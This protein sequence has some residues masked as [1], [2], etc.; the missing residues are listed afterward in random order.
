MQAFKLQITSVSVTK[1]T[2]SSDSPPSGKEYL[3]Y[4]DVKAEKESSKTLSLGLWSFGKDREAQFSGLSYVAT[5]PIRV[6][7]FAKGLFAMD[8]GVHTLYQHL[9]GDKLTTTST[10]NNNDDNNNS[11]SSGTISSVVFG[12]LVFGTR[13]RG[14]AVVRVHYR[15]APV[16]HQFQI[17]LAESR[18]LSQSSWWPGGEHVVAEAGKSVFDLGWFRPLDSS[19]QNDFKI[20]IVAQMEAKFWVQSKLWPRSNAIGS[21]LFIP[22]DEIEEGDESTLLVKS[23]SPDAVISSEEGP[24]QLSIVTVVLARRFVFIFHV[25]TEPVSTIAVP[26]LEAPSLQSTDVMAV[27]EGSV[28]LTD[29]LDCHVQVLIDG[30]ETFERYFHVLMEAKHSICILA[31]ELSLSFGLITSERSGERKP[32]TT[33]RDS[34]WVSLEDVLLE[35]VKK[36]NFFL[37]IFS[38]FFFFFFVFIFHKG[39]QRCFDSHH[40]LA[41]SDSFL[42]EQIFVSRRCCD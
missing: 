5:T 13:R 24:G 29:P 34:K 8:L 33:P 4:L 40:R 21:I 17:A 14:T 32:K 39:S 25:V 9:R 31:W 28:T 22:G 20:S 16:R 7:A 37:Q 36:G 2:E 41:S 6:R 30:L 23:L 3:V 19:S 27:P 42:C 11:S 38:F 26:L 35:K 18:C 12:T 10:S 1:P 15:L